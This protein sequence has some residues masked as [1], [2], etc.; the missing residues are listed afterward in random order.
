MR[1]IVDSGFMEMGEEERLIGQIEG[2]CIM[3]SVRRRGDVGSLNNAG[4]TADGSPNDKRSTPPMDTHDTREVTIFSKLCLGRVISNTELD[5]YEKDWPQ[6]ALHRDE[7]KEGRE[8]F[9]L[10]FLI[11]SPEEVYLKDPMPLTDAAGL[12]LVRVFA[13]PHQLIKY[14]DLYSDDAHLNRR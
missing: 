7:W 2:L 6:K 13:A 8:A 5:A 11:I 12:V 4:Q 1:I 14:V 3:S 9:A 10:Q